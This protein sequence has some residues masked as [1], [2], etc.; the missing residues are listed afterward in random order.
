MAILTYG[1]ALLFAY[2]W[3]ILETTSGP[4]LW[5]GFATVL[6]AL[7]TLF[8]TSMIY[9][10]LNPVP[11][12]ATDWTVAG[13]LVLGL[14]TGLIVIAAVASGFAYH[15]ARFQT[16][17]LV[18]TLGAAVIKNGYWHLLDKSLPTVTAGSAIGAPGDDVRSIEWPHTEA[19][20]V[21]KEMG[22]RIARKHADKLRNITRVALLGGALAT[23]VLLPS[24]L[25]LPYLTLFMALGAIVTLIGVVIERWLFFAEAKHVVTLYYGA[26][27]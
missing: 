26:E 18:L 8:T 6:S 14:L 2:A 12:W 13:Y 17:G 20:Y 27:S 24:L 23:L 16:L 22:Y 4:W 3:I 25:P 5:A 19:N 9:R 21:L 10:S 7:G 1:P 15:P 11:S